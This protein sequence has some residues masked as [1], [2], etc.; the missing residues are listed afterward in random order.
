[1]QSLSI[2]LP[3]YNEEKRLP[4]T[5]D[6]I[7]KAITDG[8]FREVTLNE[9]LVVDDGSKDRTADLA[10]DYRKILQD[11]LQIRVLRVNPN[12]GKG[13]AIHL[14]MNEAQ[15]DWILIADADTATPWNQFLKLKAANT[16]IA[17]GSRDLPQSQVLTKQSWIREIMG[18]TFNL[19]VRLITQLP[20]RDTQCG[21]KLIDKKSILPFMD[22]LRVKRFS[23]DVE[24]LMFARAYHLTISEVP[25]VWEHQDASRVNPIK[26][27]IEMLLRVIQM[28]IRIFFL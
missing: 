14:G 24:F 16:P 2:V 8:V 7:Q 21:F 10:D 28:R 9:I 23:W 4:R 15:S 25:V 19:L 11:H 17:I 5:F 26:D 1:M 20:Y 27:S 22:Q 18:K 13:N 12:Q 3:A 6:L